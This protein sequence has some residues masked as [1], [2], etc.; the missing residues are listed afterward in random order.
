VLSAKRVLKPPVLDY[1]YGVPVYGGAAVAI[2]GIAGF[3]EAHSNMP[4]SAS[5]VPGGFIQKQELAEQGVVPTTASGLSPTAY[6]LLRIGAWA[7]VIVGALTVVLGLIRY[8]SA[9]KG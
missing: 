9:A 6:D 7:L 8:W 1:R 5:G 3:I 4:V 2:A